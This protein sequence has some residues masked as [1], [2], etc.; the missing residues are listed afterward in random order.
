[1]AVRVGSR[2]GAA[3]VS[4]TGEV[5]LA[6]TPALEQTLR[7]VTDDRTDEVIVELTGCTF[8]DSQGLSALVAT[9]GRLERS[10]GRLALVVSNPSVLK[11]FQITQ[12]DE[13]FQIYPSLGAAGDGNGN[14]RRDG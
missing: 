4:V 11:I 5:D 14:G 9:K 8:L 1:M 3:V 7:G 13:P 10:N 12:V 6:T 2:G